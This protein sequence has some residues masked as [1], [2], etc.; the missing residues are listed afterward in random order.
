MNKRIIG[1]VFFL[2]MSL[3]TT[4]VFAKSS[5]VGNWS[6][7]KIKLH[8]KLNH[9]YTYTVKVLG[10]KK[11]FKGTWKTKTV[12]KKSGKKAHY[13]VMTYTLF[14]KHKKVSEYSFRK[15]KLRLIQNGKVYYLN[16]S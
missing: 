16:R 7:S 9:K 6:S 8:L 1:V 2:V 5:L 15:G 11:T 3:V 4:S 13:L 10:I 12:T 14:G